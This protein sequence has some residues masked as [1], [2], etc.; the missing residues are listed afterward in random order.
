M[1][2]SCEVTHSFNL[3]ISCGKWMDSDRNKPVIKTGVNHSIAKSFLYIYNRWML[4]I[5]RYD[6]CQSSMTHRETLTDN[7]HDHRTDIWIFS[8]LPA[9]MKSA[10][11]WTMLD[12]TNQQGNNILFHSFCPFAYF[13]SFGNHLVLNNDKIVTYRNGWKWESL[14]PLQVFKNYFYYVWILSLKI[15]WYSDTP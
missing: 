10:R 15:I 5:P 13:Y 7:N 14:L 4:R 8:P 9:L 3:S 12:M 2:P 6:P 11:L 1:F